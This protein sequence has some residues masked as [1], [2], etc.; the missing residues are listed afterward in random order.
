M[1]KTNSKL[2]TNSAY[3]KTIKEKIKPLAD[4]HNLHFKKDVLLLV[5]VSKKFRTHLKHKLYKWLFGM[6]KKQKDCFKNF[7]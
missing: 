5:D 6:K 4:Y 2:T 7:C 3:G 1:E